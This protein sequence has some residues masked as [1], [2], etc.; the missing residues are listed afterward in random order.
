MF[1]CN[2]GFLL[3]CEVVPFSTPA[4]TNVLSDSEHS[5]FDFRFS[6]PRLFVSSD[7]SITTNPQPQKRQRRHIHRRN[8]HPDRPRAYGRG[9]VILQAHQ[10]QP[11][12]VSGP[13]YI[14]RP[15]SS[16][17]PIPVAILNTASDRERRDVRLGLDHHVLVETRE[18][19]Q[20]ER[21][22]DQRDGQHDVAA[23]ERGGETVAAFDPG[24]DDAGDDGD[25]AGEETSV[26]GFDTPGCL[27]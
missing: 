17:V 10:A 24:D 8:Q 13:L 27:S 12:S 19:D 16:L 1:L 15:L 21:E 18:P 6:C 22:E 14:C 26:E 11:L 7:T 25:A 4:P 5:I 3:V 9:Q 20:R 2:R 23:V